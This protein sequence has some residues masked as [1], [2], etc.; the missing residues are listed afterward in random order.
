[1]RSAL[2]E[3]LAQQ[4]LSQAPALVEKALQ[5]QNSLHMRFGVMLVGP[6]GMRFCQVLTE[7][8][9]SFG[10]LASQCL[11]DTILALQELERA[12]AAKFCR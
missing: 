4:G 10:S 5:L 9:I 2:E 3:V 11:T 1:M 8:K 12:P 6:A 7:A